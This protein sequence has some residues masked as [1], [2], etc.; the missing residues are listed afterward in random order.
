[1]VIRV[2]ENPC[3]REAATGLLPGLLPVLIEHTLSSSPSPSTATSES[4]RLALDLLVAAARAARASALRPALPQLILAG[5]MAMAGLPA[6]RLP[7]LLKQSD[8]RRI[9]ASSSSAMVL[10]HTSTGLSASSIAIGTLSDAGEQARQT[11][12]DALAGLVIAKDV[13]KEEQMAE[14]LRLVTGIK[15]TALSNAPGSV[16]CGGASGAASVATAACLFLGQ[17]AANQMAANQSAAAAR[18]LQI[19]RGQQHHCLQQ[20]QQHLY[21]HGYH[22]YHQHELQQQQQ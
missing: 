15:P 2:L 10:P 6:S 18:Q 12:M 8:T 1:M 17:L 3:Y 5:L 22:H 16:R 14:V 4:S 13:S 7:G 11:S 19:R 9:A 21:N 20:Q